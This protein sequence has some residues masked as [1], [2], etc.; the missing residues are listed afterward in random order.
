MIGYGAESGEIHNVKVIENFETF[1]KSANT[2]SSD[3][4]FKSYGHWKLGKVSVL[5]GLNCLDNFGL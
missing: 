1:P 4:Q 5:D 2:P 3:Q